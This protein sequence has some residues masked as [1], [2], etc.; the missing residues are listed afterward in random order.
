[1][2]TMAKHIMPAAHRAT[3]ELKDLLSA[4]DFAKVEEILRYVR[5]SENMQFQLA[6]RY[7]QEGKTFDEFMTS[8]TKQVPFVNWG[9]KI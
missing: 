4:Q 9:N 1:M 2:K 5:Q 8:F 6:W 3:E 7:G